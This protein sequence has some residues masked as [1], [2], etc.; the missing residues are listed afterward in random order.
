MILLWVI[1]SVAISEGVASVAI[2]VLAVLVLA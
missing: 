2:T 1:P